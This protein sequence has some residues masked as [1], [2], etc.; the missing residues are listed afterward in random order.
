MIQS[1][2]HID[3][4]SELMLP[5]YWQWNVFRVWVWRGQTMECN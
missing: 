1:I 3:Y 5:C 4:T 2:F